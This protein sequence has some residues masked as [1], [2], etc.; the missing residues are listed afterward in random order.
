MN[1]LIWINIKFIL[2]YRYSH[3]WFVKTK[4]THTNKLESTSVCDSCY[5]NIVDGKC[6][7]C[8]QGIY[9]ETHTTRKWSHQL[10][11]AL[12]FPHKNT[13]GTPILFF[14]PRQWNI[15]KA[16]LCKCALTTFVSFPVQFTSST[17]MT[18]FGVI[19]ILTSIFITFGESQKC[20]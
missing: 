9:V 11:V 18:V 10:S 14:A 3:E 20:L 15:L 6:M 12:I 1:L 13:R 8:H 16:T 5:S 19:V 17:T 7:A 2:C 4:G